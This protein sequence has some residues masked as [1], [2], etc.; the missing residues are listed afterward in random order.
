LA[1]FNVDIYLWLGF[2]EG[3][4]KSGLCVCVGGWV[5]VYVC[6]LLGISNKHAQ[7]PLLF[8]GIE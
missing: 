2:Q 3:L 8:Y 1:S 4:H 5:C 7:W 6:V